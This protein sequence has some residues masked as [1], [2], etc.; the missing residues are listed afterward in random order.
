MLD[1]KSQRAVCFVVS[2]REEGE[3]P[4]EFELVA[5]GSHRE[6]LSHMSGVSSSQVSLGLPAEMLCEL[7]VFCEILKV[8]NGL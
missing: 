7:D 8:A 5:S 1:S 3:R 2:E 6:I 4:R